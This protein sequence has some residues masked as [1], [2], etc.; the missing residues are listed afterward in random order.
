MENLSKM[1]IEE[2]ERRLG[3]LEEELDELEEEKNFVLK[4]T[5]L[6][7]S[8]G[9]VKQYEAQTQYLNQS[10]SELREELMQRSSQLKDNNW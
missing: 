3:V 7:I 4:Q 10:I 9:K 6:H 8:G 5:G 2:L 1:K